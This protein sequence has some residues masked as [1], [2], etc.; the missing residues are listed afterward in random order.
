MKNEYVISADD[1]DLSEFERLV[2]D[3]HPQLT[4]FR[5]D[6]K[7]SY[8]HPLF[9]HE[10][11]TANWLPGNDDDYCL[12]AYSLFN[13]THRDNYILGC[14]KFLE[15]PYGRKQDKGIGK[16]KSSFEELVKNTNSELIRQLSLLVEE[17]CAIWTDLIREYVINP[18]DA[19]IDS[20]LQN[21]IIDKC[22]KVSDKLMDISKSD[23]LEFGEL[24][25]LDSHGRYGV[26]AKV[27]IQEY[28]KLLPSR[29]KVFTAFWVAE[30]N[31]KKLKM[32]EGNSKSVKYIPFKTRKIPQ[33]ID[34][35]LTHNLVKQLKSREGMPSS[36]CD[37]IYKVINKNKKAKSRDLRAQYR[38]LFIKACLYAFLK[39][40]SATL[41][42]TARQIASD[43]AFF[44]MSDMK[45]LAD[46]ENE[47][48]R[49]ELEEVRFLDLKNNLSAW[50]NKKS[51]KGYIYG[52]ILLNSK[53]QI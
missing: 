36:P 7:P 48:D 52:Q 20:E 50:A 37:Y 30:L 34:V 6:G 31:D 8:E 29:I 44:Y 10:A 41:T 42:D 43:D 15:T 25:T 51:E 3:F 26:L 53:D 39:E 40:Y 1:P 18:D 45:K 5:K 46:Y 21:W 32:A 38:W 35:V 23:E 47:V 33:Y 14:H 27:L 16:L 9:F 11:P 2:A 49:E 17:S 19:Y 24:K 22:Q 13:K 4:K 28:Q 12:F